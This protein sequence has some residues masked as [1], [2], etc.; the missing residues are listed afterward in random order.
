[1]RT[2]VI[3]D[4]H[5]G[6]HSG[7]DVLR[8]TE[9]RAALLGA[10]ADVDRLVLLGDLL[11]L[12]HGPARDALSAARLPLSELGAALPAAAE[13]V[14][15]PGN[16][17]HDLLDGWSQRQGRHAAPAPLM[18]STDISF[19]ADELLGVMAGWL[20]A[21]RVRVSYPGVWLRE[22]VLAVHG[23]YLDVHLAIPSL[24]R[25]AAGVM[26]RIVALGPDGP[27]SIEDYEAILAPIYAWVRALADRLPPAR[28]GHLHSG[29]TRGWTA[30]TGARRGLRRR[31]AAIGYRVGIAALNRAGLGP[32]DSALSSASLRR[33][34][35]RALEESL[36]RLGAAAPYVLFGHTHRA[37][38]LPDD[39]PD[40]WRTAVGGRLINTGCWVQDS[41]F[42]GREPRRSPYRPGFAVWLE[43]AGPPQL[44]NLLDG[45]RGG[46][47]LIE[48]EPDPG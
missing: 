34:G 12:R 26:T 21:D 22:D 24:E 6:V 5:L 41:S 44:V 30:L 8:R 4:L 3:S 37:G 28:G 27:T 38:P 15:V 25:L 47:E 48:A 33:A 7:G 17:D 20:G 32:L 43:E 1:M 2:L 46:A 42:T 13:V 40:V 9:P 39:D 45:W 16:H 11:E 29:S 35:L 14:I 19:G 10:I 36:A 23:Q 18:L 31:I